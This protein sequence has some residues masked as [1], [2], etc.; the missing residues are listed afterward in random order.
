M[1]IQMIIHRAGQPVEVT[2][3]VVRVESFTVSAAQGVQVVP[4]DEAGKE[5][6]IKELLRIESGN[7]HMNNHRL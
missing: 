4:L 6:A 7:R 5:F 3:D 1:K 2:V